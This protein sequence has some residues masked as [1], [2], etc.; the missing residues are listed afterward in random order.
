[1]Q[2]PEP[3]KRKWTQP[4]KVQNFQPACIPLKGVEDPATNTSEDC[5]FLNVYVPGTIKFFILTLSNY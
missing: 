1:M 2:A 4:L 3:L 5:L